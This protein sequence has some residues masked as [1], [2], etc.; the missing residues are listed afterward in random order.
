MKLNERDILRINDSDKLNR[1]RPGQAGLVTRK[2]IYLWRLSSQDKQNKSASYSL[3]DSHSQYIYLYEIP[4]TTGG[5]RGGGRDTHKL[6]SKP[7]S[8]I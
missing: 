4:E 5:G 2:Q 8:R 6:P 3:F 7:G 1:P